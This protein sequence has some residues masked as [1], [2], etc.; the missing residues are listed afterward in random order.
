MTNPN[1]GML[2]RPVENLDEL[3]DE[4]VFVGNC[5]TGILSPLRAPLR[6]EPLKTS[7]RLSKRLHMLNTKNSRRS[8]GKPV[9]GKIPETTHRFAGDLKKK[10]FST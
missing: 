4:L 3:T 6:S 7:T 5:T 1:L 2:R 9:F 10:T 8:S